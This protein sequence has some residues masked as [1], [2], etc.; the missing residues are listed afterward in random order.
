VTKTNTRI[1]R[2]NLKLVE[3]ICSTMV[4]VGGYDRDYVRQE[5]MDPWLTKHAAQPAIANMEL[6]GK[7]FRL[8]ECTNK[9]LGSCK[10]HVLLAL[11]RELVLMGEPKADDTLVG[12]HTTNTM[13]LAPV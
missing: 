10:D 4:L 2:L 9:D 7:I 11:D 12:H 1:D 3:L 6:W 8:G 5:I 13:V